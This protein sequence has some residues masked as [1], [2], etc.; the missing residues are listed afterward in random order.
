[1][2][3]RPASR[4]SDAS[5]AAPYLRGRY[6][7]VKLGGTADMAAGRVGPDVRRLVEAGARV[8]VAH[9]GGDA[10][11]EWLRARGRQSRWIEGV[12]V[13]DAA[14]RDAA[15]MIFRGVVAPAV[16]GRLA[17]A[18]VSAIGLAGPDGGLIRV[19]SRGPQFGFVGDV[20]R[21]NTELLDHLTAQGHVPVVAPLGLGPRQ[22]IFNINGDDVA[23]ALARAVR[24]AALVFLTD[25]DGVYD[26]RG[27]L[28]RDLPAPA[29]RALIRADVIQGGMLPKVR[30]A[31]RLLPY[32]DA[33]WIANGARPNILRRALIDRRAGTRIVSS[34]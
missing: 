21:V 25:V 7:V 1:M 20:R 5:E 22:E 30:A 14:T 18:G 28:L 3:A 15:V 32:I 33:V 13:T 34:A 29:A 16:V 10:L 12:R 8:V 19:R 9:G 24:A 23:A 27:R 11:S 31:L 17:A 26:A 2:S 6:I 4:R